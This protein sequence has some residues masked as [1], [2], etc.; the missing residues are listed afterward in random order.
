MSSKQRKDQ[1][2]VIV[3]FRDDLRLAD[4]PALH[5]AGE[6][7][8][9]VIPL[10]ILDEQ[11]AGTRAF[12]G[13]QRWWLHHSLASLAEDIAGLGSRLVLRR[14]RAA[15][16]L[17]DVVGETGAFAIHWNRRYDPA[18]VGVDRATKESFSGR[19]IEVHSFAGRLLH[20]PARLET[21]SGG[22]YKV[23]TPFWRAI[24]GRQDPREPLPAP[25]RLP[26]PRS[27]P[28]S[29]RLEDWGLLPREPDWSGGIARTWTPGEAA[30]LD[31]L[32][33]FVEDGLK[34]YGRRRDDPADPE[35]TSGL[36]PHLALGE[37][38][39]YQVWHATRNLP[40]DIARQD[41]TTFRKEIVWREFCH[42]LLYHFP[43]MR[44]ENYNSR[45][46]GFDWTVDRAALKAWQQGRTGYPIVDAGMRQLWQTGWMHN[47]VRMV[48]AS[49]LTKHLLLDWREGEA[50]F[51][52]TL[53]DADPASNAANWQWVAGSGADAA[54]YFR[55]FN[56]I[57]Q[58][59]KFD[60][61]GDYVRR[62]VPE[63]AKL[64]A[65]HIHKPWAA[66][67]KV[68]EEAGIELGKSYP[69]PIVEHKSARQR[70]LAAYDRI[71]D[72]A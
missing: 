51:W 11:S 43:Q 26:A 8:A 32:A 10:F 69:E 63:L 45:F 38:S 30:A 42:H 22:P 4:N 6:T 72:A 25:G 39:P 41:R 17:D 55:I 71:K 21:T 46:D 68:L 18:G 1:Q 50:W 2:P 27:F 54:P 64:P 35:G 33:R 24:E 15:D 66:P 58:G 40:D 52:D 70:A 12:G 31:R 48:V 36:S 13:A 3:W 65:K 49:F 34:G 19:G 37:I 47:R 56:P 20:E 44:Q 61:R 28:E 57:L 53:V 29:E 7:G 9:P 60:P 62:F 23:Y 14:G 5:L 59:E 16:V 67:Q